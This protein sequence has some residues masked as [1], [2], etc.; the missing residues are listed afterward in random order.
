ML[1][2]ANRARSLKAECDEARRNVIQEEMDVVNHN[3]T[4][5]LLDLLHGHRPFGLK[6]VYK[7]KA[8]KVIK[9]KVRPVIRRYVQ[10]PMID[11]NELFVPVTRMEPIRLLFA[12]VA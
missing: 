8:A 1:D 6:W 12:L 3:G 4:W 5:E 11:F 9:H 2:L 7:L 10:Q